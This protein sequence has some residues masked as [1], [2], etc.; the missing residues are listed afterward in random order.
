MR[1]RTEDVATSDN[2]HSSKE[3]ASVFESSFA[4]IFE[5]ESCQAHFS[6]RNYLIINILY[7]CL[8]YHII[9]ISYHILYHIIYMMYWYDCSIW[10][11]LYHM[12]HSWL[13]NFGA[14]YAEW[15]ILTHLLQTLG[16]HNRNRIFNL[17]KLNRWF[18]VN[19]CSICNSVASIPLALL[20]SIA[21]IIASKVGIDLSILQF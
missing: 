15:I 8:W 20:A 2:L 21:T 5:S 7:A 18:G 14:E 3:S 10:Y 17:C 6:L 16:W 4:A 9:I 19:L 1:S 13:T 11:D 12:S